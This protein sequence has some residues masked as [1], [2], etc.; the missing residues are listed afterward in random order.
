MLTQLTPQGLRHHALTTQVDLIAP[1][2]VCYWCHKDCDLIMS[3]PCAICFHVCFR[4]LQ[5][6]AQQRCGCC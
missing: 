6:G 4:A 3:M 2:L 1:Q 5:G